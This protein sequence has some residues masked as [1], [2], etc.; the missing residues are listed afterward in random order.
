MKY[1]EGIVERKLAW[2]KATRKYFISNCPDSGALLRSAE[3]SQ[4]QEVT[5]AHVDE[6]GRSG[7]CFDKEPSNVS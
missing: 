1:A 3:D 5:A 2:T 4:V 6:S 7:Y